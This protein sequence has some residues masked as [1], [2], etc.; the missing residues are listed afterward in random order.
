MCCDH[1]VLVDDFENVR[2]IQ[3]NGHRAEYGDNEKYVQ[4]KTVDD[5]GHVLPILSYLII[6]KTH[7]NP[8]I[9]S[10]NRSIDQTST[11]LNV[12][13]LVSQMLG[14]ELDGFRRSIRCGTQIETVAGRRL[15]GRSV[16]GRSVDQGRGDLADRLGQ[17]MLD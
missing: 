7:I 17:R 12:F 9:Q 8:I 15:G 4:L 2:R 14:N 5:H 10:I 13:V 3:Q 11:N 6:S 16:F 1:F